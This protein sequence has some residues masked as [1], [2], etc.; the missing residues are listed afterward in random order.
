MAGIL[1]KCF[2]MVALISCAFSSCVM[3]HLYYASSKRALVRLHVDWTK[4]GLSPNGVSAYVYNG[5]EN[6]FVDVYI[7]SN[8][9]VIDVN[10]PEGKYDIVVFNNT[11][12]ELPHVELGGM[13]KRSTFHIYAK[14]AGYESVVQ[15]ASNSNMRLVKNPNIVAAA[16]ICNV[17]ITE[18]MVEYY[19][20]IPNQE[21][22]QEVS[23]QYNVTPMHI[24]PV[25][26][27]KVHVKGLIY[28]LS[29]PKALLRGVS[30][31]YSFFNEA[32]IPEQ[33]MHEFVLNN[34]VFLNNDK[35]DGVISKEFDLFGLHAN[36]MKAHRY[37]LDMRFIL[38]DKSELFLSVDVTDK[39]E[40]I[41]TGIRKQI[42]IN[43]DIELPE[44]GGSGGE[45]GDG[46][47]DPS[48]DPWEDIDVVLPM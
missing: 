13:D 14:D 12:S 28:A 27:V 11:I 32:T 34:R 48:L 19:P 18:Q 6:E 3:D 7:N 33:V 47:F 23:V 35:V 21:Y 39:I 46:S 4:S 31:G 17:E 15:N 10:L 36:A 20:E 30:G 16:T 2:L 1:M 43:V 42:K 5:A 45:D 22:E 24:V 44:T 26:E 40:E 41:F 8:P 38:I 25:A 29:A 9:N 37:Y